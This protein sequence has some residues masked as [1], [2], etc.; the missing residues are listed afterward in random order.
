LKIRR[1]LYLNIEGIE[2]MHA[3]SLDKWVRHQ[4]Y[5]KTY[6]TNIKNGF[7]LGKLWDSFDGLKDRRGYARKMIT[8]HCN[9][10]A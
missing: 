4:L 10:E 1:Y 6:I 5:M 7:P 8:G 9:E 2:Y 3:W